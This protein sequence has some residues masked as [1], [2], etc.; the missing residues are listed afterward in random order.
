[1]LVTRILQ[2]HDISIRKQLSQKEKDGMTQIGNVT[3]NI[4]K[5]ASDL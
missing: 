2:E 4:H 5:F 1:M 3:T